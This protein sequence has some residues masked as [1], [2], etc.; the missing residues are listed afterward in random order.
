MEMNYPKIVKIYEKE[1]KIFD[2]TT[3]VRT[4]AIRVNFR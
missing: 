4:L 2:A 1:S 3:H